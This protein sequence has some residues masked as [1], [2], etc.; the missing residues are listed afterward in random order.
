MSDFMNSGSAYFDV[1]PQQQAPNPD[2]LSLQAHALLSP[3]ALLPAGKPVSGR[4]PR[5]LR[6]TMVDHQETDAKRAPLAG[7]TGIETHSAHASQ[8]PSSAP[9][10]GCKPEHK[11]A[12]EPRIECGPAAPEDVGI[13]QSKVAN[14]NSAADADII[15]DII[16]IWRIRMDMLRARQR[17]ELQAM[18]VCR[19]FCDGDKTAGAKLWAKVKAAEAD[20]SLTVR[21]TP[22]ILAMAP[23]DAAKADAEKQLARLAQ[24]TQIHAWAKGVLGFGEVSLAA[25]IGECA[26]GPGDY[27]S[28]SALW[29]RMGLAVIDGER[30]RKVTGA[31]ALDHGY[32]AERRSLMWN[33]AGT[34]IKAQLRSEKD[35]DGKKVEGSSFARGEL[36][37]VYLARKAYQVARNAERGEKP[38]SPLHIHN[39]AAR[40]MA[41]RLLRQLWQVWR[42]TYGVAP[43]PEAP[44]D[45][46][47]PRQASVPAQTI[48]AAPASEHRR[49]A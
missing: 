38:W 27:R 7:Q 22:I 2:P 13:G 33:I 37:E 43:R 28:V 17:L 45:N 40:Y 36:G 1:S 16:E 31:A 39:D 41:K 5:A 3:N 8:T 15:N 4:K 18:A 26:R 49:D 48:P 30:Q 25:V 46:E 14:Q 44:A 47:I 12:E 35:D 24:K 6:Q 34:I 29:K 10:P 20:L 42:R 32:N 9:G 23:L 19:R 11:R 21:L